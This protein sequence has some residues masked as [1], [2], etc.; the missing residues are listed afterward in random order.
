LTVATPRTHLAEIAAYDKALHASHEELRADR[1]ELARRNWRL[2]FP[3]LEPTEARTNHFYLLGNV[4][5]RTLADIAERAEKV[6]PEVAGLLKIPS[7][8][9]RC[10]WFDDALR[11]VGTVRLQ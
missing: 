4:G 11:P 2:S 7:G 6:V 9:A 8:T 5:E 1:E 3:G 10:P